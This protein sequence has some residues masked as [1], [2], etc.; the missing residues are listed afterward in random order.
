M[1]AKLAVANNQLN[2]TGLFA[3]PP[4]QLWGQGN[5]LLRGI[6][7]SFSPFGVK[8]SDIRFETLA[9]DITGQV[10]TANL[11][12]AGFCRFRFDKVEAT[13]F[14]F[15]KSFLAEFPKICEA[16]TTWIRREAKDFEISSHRFMYSCH[17]LLGDVRVAEWLNFGRIIITD[18][19]KAQGTGA[20]FHWS[21]PEKSWTTQL[22]L[23]KSVVV[24]DGLYLMFTLDV[25]KNVI[26]FANIAVEARSYL[27]AIIAQLGLEFVQEPG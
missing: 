19:G 7:D 2:Y 18:A 20:I 12:T 1:N 21:Q 9:A 27:D 16:S 23:D 25:A 22:V 24:P 10:I 4:F 26:P 14:N 8:A 5:V 11:G 15:G 17:G 6:Y 13:F 3:R